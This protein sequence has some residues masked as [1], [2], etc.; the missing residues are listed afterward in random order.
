MSMAIGIL[1]PTAI[2]GGL[3]LLF[4]IILAAASRIFEVKLDARLQKVIDALPG[5]NCGAC[6]FLSCEAL[7]NEICA[8]HRPPDTC[9]VGGPASAHA[10]AEIMGV[11]LENVKETMAVVHCQGSSQYANSDFVLHSVQRCA[12]ANVLSDGQKTCGT[13]CLGL[14]DCYRACKFD[15]ITIKDNC[16]TIDPEK[17][18]SCGSCVRA[19]P[20]HI[21]CLTDKH[22]PIHVL[23]SSH[24]S[25]KIV[26]NACKI[27]C[28]GCRKC[29]RNCEFDAIHVVDSLAV[30]DETKCTGCLKCVE[31]CPTHCIVSSKEMCLR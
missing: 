20:K 25:G 15:A 12:A 27:G 28:I 23:C 6:G 5:A 22:V 24:D 30:V 11:T 1:A 21:I 17:C 4:G 9:K 16:A 14:G 2:L 18:T 8:G 19:C 3:G 29:E 13:A 31:E 10:V 7:A 26:I